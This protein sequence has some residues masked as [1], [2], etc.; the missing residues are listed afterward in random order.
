VT[1]A[2]TIQVPP[3]TGKVVSAEWDFNGAGNFQS[4]NC[5][6]CNGTRETATLSTTQT[7]SKAGTYF[8]GLRATSQRNGDTNTNLNQISAYDFIYNLGR[9]RVVVH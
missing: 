1:F 7:Y 8:A 5:A 2:A 6:Q 9:V 4:A 3:G